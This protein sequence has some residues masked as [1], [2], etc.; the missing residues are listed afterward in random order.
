[1]SGVVIGLEIHVS[2]KSASKLFCTCSADY[3]NAKPNSNVCEVC[4]GQPGSK[5]RAVNEKAIENALKIASALECQPEKGAVVV[6]R[7]HYWYPDLPSGYQRTSRPLGRNGRLLGVGITEVHF[8]ED[9]GRYE[10]KT[11]FVDFN[12]SGSPLLEVVTEPDMTSP[13]Q[14]REFLDELQAI[15]EYLDAAKNDAGSTRIDANV[16]IRG[17]SRV[18]VKNINSFKG[19]FI[20][21]TYEIARQKNLLKNNMTVVQ[22]TR[23]FDEDRNITLGLRKKE[24]VDDYRYVPDPDIPPLELSTEHVEK[25]KKGLPELP[26]EKRE[27]FL[28]QY[29]IREEEAFTICL[30]KEFAD[31]FEAGSK[32]VD[33]KKLARFMRGMLKKQLNWR[34]LSFKDSKLT[35]GL[36]A[37]FV[38]MVEKKE[39]TEKVV[40]QL[41][42]TF[43][44][45]GVPPRVHAE[46]EGLLGIHK[47][48][49]LE[50]AIEKVLAGNKKAVEDYLQGEEKALHFLAGQVMK[51][52]KGKAA[53]N[54]V[55]EKLK[56][57]MK[58]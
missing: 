15:L 42:I 58:K 17:S 13:K 28:K 44:D 41:V 47:E 10:L 11:G 50:E 5:P 37:D 12:R 3:R 23:H 43:L 24:T 48:T 8:E 55:L 21:L 19:V 53:P 46:K 20:A 30:E 39:V 31:A 7:K 9:P 35:V 18:E 26:R 1:M 52:T 16:S 27:R 25:V 34:G 38:D 36:V 29:G 4:T 22:E 6:Q 40:E 33:A 32:K 57:K 54:E 49:K 51:A 14:A 2:L 56:N 45:R